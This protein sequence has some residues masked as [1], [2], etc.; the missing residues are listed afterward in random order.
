VF[1]LSPTGTETV[2]HSFTGAADGGYPEASLIRDAAG[3]LYGTT[4]FGGAN[5]QGV[6]FK[7]SP[8]GTLT[9]L[10]SF[11]GGADG[12]RPIAGLIQDPAGNLYGT[13]WEGGAESSACANPTCGVVFKLSPDGTETCSTP[14]LG[15]RT[16]EVPPLV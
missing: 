4:Q 5:D 6:V 1:K 2:L 11:T 14:S 13:T 3:N 12:Q 10:Y 7:L 9:L 15:E 16:E 8:T